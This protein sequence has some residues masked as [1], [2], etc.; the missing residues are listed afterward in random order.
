MA[1]SVSDV[2]TTFLNQTGLMKP[3]LETRLVE[4]WPEIMGPQVADLTSKIEV[5]DGVLYV[6][7]HSAALRQQLF[8]CRFQ[9]RDRLNAAMNAQVIRDIRLLG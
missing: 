7:I 3:I 8:E 5:K 6:H 4:R 2:L 1:E 9:L